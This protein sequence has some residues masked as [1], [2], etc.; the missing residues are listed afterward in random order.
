MKTMRSYTWPVLMA[1]V[2]GLTAFADVVKDSFIAEMLAY[3]LIGLGVAALVFFKAPGIS[4]LAGRWFPGVGRDFSPAAFAVSCGILGVLVFGFAQMS[5]RLSDQGGAIAAAFPEVAHFQEQLGLVQNDIS[6][7]ASATELVTAEV[8][9][10]SADT[11]F[12][13]EAA[14]KWIQFERLDVYGSNGEFNFDAI[15]IDSVDI[16]VKNASDKTV[17]FEDRNQLIAPGDSRLWRPEMSHRPEQLEVCISGQRRVD[18]VW[19]IERRIY[20]DAE[21]AIEGYYQYRVIQTN[22]LEVGDA[23]TRCA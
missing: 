11:K 5:A 2:S 3:A 6:R 9:K 18:G 14:G 22:G 17:Y 10:V 12:L 4:R 20:G 16:I 21:G 8:E 1:L 7:I 23:N 19:T 15:F 13:T